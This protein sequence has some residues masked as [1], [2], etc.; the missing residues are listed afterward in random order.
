M[1]GIEL[2]TKEREEQLKKHSHTDEHD[3]IHDEKELLHAASY[4]MF[5]KLKDPVISLYAGWSYFTDKIDEKNIVDR[6][7]V[8]GALIA[9]EIDRLQR[10]AKILD[11]NNNTLPIDGV[12]HPLPIRK[13]RMEGYTDDCQCKP[14]KLLESIFGNCG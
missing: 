13:D 5:P 12:S 10:A 14:C 2:I 3:S 11:K 1:T 4:A 7:K 6:L 8:A 9:A